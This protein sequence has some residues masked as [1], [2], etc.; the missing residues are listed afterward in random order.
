MTQFAPGTV[1]NVKSGTSG[2]DCIEMQTDRPWTYQ[3]N[4]DAIRGKEG[5]I[6]VFNPQ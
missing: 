6:K 3:V 4:R 5:L 1:F 2:F